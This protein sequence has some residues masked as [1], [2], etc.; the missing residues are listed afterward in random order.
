MLA[1]GLIAFASISI[2]TSLLY[3]AYR[4]KDLSLSF[5]T[6]SLKEANRELRTAQERYDLLFENSRF[7]V[8]EWRQK[9]GR[10]ELV[11]SRRLYSML[12]MNPDDFKPCLGSYLELVH[13][14][15][16]ENV[17]NS[18]E[19]MKLER[20]AQ[21]LEYRML[22]GNDYHWMRSRTAIR[23]DENGHFLFG[24]GSIEDIQEIKEA[25]QMLEEEVRKRTLQLELANVTKDRFLANMSHE[26]RTPLG[27]I[28]GFSE[29]LSGNLS[30]DE[31]AHEYINLIIKNG[32]ILSRLINDL[33]DLSRVEAGM[34]KFQWSKVNINDLIQEIQNTF[35]ERADRKKIYLNFRSRLP[36]DEVLITD[37]I[38]LKQ[39]IYNL[40]SNA[41]KFT[42]VGGVSVTFARD[43]AAEHYYLDVVDTGIGV[44]ESEKQKIF[45]E[46]HRSE[47]VEDRK[48]PGSGL[49]L[50]LAK[51]LCQALGGDLHLLSSQV[52]EGSHF[53]ATFCSMSNDK[54]NVA[55]NKNPT[56]PASVDFSKLRIGVLDDNEDNLKLANI[57]LK[58]IG[59]Q[60]WSWNDPI[61]FLAECSTLNPDLVLLDIQ[62]PKMSGFEVLERLREQGFENPV[63]ALTAYGMNDD[64]QKILEKG[65]EAFIRKPIHIEKF[66]AKLIEE[67][68]GPQT[69]SAA[70]SEIQTHRFTL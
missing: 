16:R 59:C 2:P 32:E 28:L 15:D 13:P 70:F 55:K 41:I 53:R 33:L 8:Y 69:E 67:F 63:W 12:N 26:L 34:L 22:V 68:R 27:L 35:D 21:S 25:K 37:P 7:G 31:E 23:H 57:F 61:S 20:E 5:S 10:T 48:Y 58:K 62:M 54:L 14:E 3:L 30:V 52:G 46:Y 36:S 50:K 18:A 17:L 38:R 4:R 9:Q 43:Q 64:V 11:W 60:V 29:L 6:R 47:I 24:I 51:N 1:D 49:G 56:I 42:D 40:I 66:K 39:I 44:D 19:K 45:I 65:F